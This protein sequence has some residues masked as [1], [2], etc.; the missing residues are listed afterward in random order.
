WGPRRDMSV[1]DSPPPAP[2][3]QTDVR[4]AD[5][6]FDKRM[7]VVQSIS[8]GGGVAYRIWF[9][10]G[11][12]T[13]A[14]PVTVDQE[15]G[16]LFSDPGVQIADCNGDRVPD[17]AQVRP[18]GVVVTAGLGYGHF[19]PAI[20]MLLSDYTLDSTQVAR[21]KLTDLNG[22]GLADLVIERA[23]P[24]ECWYWLNLGNY[25]F[26]ARKV[27]T[28]L[29]T[30]LGQNAVTRWADINGNG[31]TDLIYADQ[32]STPR[33]QTVDLGE[34]VGG[35]TT[36]N[37]LTSI[38]NGLGRVTLIGYAPSTSFALADA[39]AGRSWTNLM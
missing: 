13:Y 17:I 11:N 3:G 35:S 1:Q 33:L 23:A 14:P 37:V 6:D 38:S 4:T 20:T 28:G 39:A 30:G 2:F 5:L 24:G 29:P 18:I 25:T 26:S 21:A 36:P 7:D 32:F 8:T 27:I 16:F 15:A 9:N 34:L 10:S 12:Q 19:A 22:D 31:T